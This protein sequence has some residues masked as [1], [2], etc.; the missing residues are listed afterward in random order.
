MYLWGIF[1][2]FSYN[3]ENKIMNNKF[4][5]ISKYGNEYKIVT[6][7]TYLEIFSSW[8]IYLWRIF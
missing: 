3:N 4:K 5:I 7:V 1:N 6:W 8:L 2:R